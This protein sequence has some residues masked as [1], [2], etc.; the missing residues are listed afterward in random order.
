[1]RFPKIYHML[2]TWERIRTRFV[3]ST[4]HFTFSV[5]LWNTG[6]KILNFATKIAVDEPRGAFLQHLWTF[7]SIKKRSCKYN[8]YRSLLALPVCFHSEKRR[9]FLNKKI[10]F[11]TIPATP[12]SISHKL[13]LEQIQTSLSSFQFSKRIQTFRYSV[14]SPITVTCYESYQQFREPIHQQHL[15]CSSSASA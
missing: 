11:Q 15:T 13:L 1:M 5:E 9:S 3:T 14:S 10:N 7:M 12:V 2:R 6:F 4:V 8:R